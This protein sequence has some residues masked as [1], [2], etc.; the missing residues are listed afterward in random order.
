[1]SDPC[2]ACLLEQHKATCLYQG[3]LSC[4][5]YV[6]FDHESDMNDTDCWLGLGGWFA[7]SCNNSHSSV[8]DTSWQPH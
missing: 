4:A 1:M 2:Q 5:L 7:Q 3:G 8:S 6:T